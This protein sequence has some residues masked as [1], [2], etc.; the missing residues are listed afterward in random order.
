MA[1]ELTWGL[2]HCRL[3]WVSPAVAVSLCGAPGV[4]NVGVAA[5]ADTAT[6]PTLALAPS[7]P[8]RTAHTLML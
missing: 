4:P 2:S 8:L 3:T 7:A 1:P 5:E 6:G